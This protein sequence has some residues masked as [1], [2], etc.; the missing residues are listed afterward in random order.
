MRKS[1][2]LLVAP[3]L[4]GSLF[5]GAMP[6]VHAASKTTKRR[7]ATTSATKATTA[8]KATSA[9]TAKKTTL[10]SRRTV[11]T[12]SNASGPVTSTGTANVPAPTPAGTCPLLSRAEVLAF[13]PSHE[14]TEENLSPMHD[15][16][17]LG[18]SPTNTQDCYFGTDTV[19][20]VD[21]EGNGVPGYQTI[22]S[23]NYHRVGPSGYAKLF[24]NPEP[25]F[26]KGG[27]PYEPLPG[28]GAKALIW[29]QRDEQLR[30]EVWWVIFN[31]SSVVD[32]HFAAFVA[33]DYAGSVDWDGFQMAIMKAIASRMT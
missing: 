30:Q 26:V 24:A 16:A 12:R 9:T 15:V 14:M 29:Y 8:K 6:S 23:F 10:P 25:L 22:S 4:L 33:D 7:T 19:G 27:G 28:V 17:S 2:F 32:G 13:H 3:L 31:K 5:L 20:G 18:V 11:A 21:N 1:A